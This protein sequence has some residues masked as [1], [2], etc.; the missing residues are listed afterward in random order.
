MLMSIS[1]SHGEGRLVLTKLTIFSPRSVLPVFNQAISC[2]YQVSTKLWPTGILPGSDP[3]ILYHP[4]S[5][6]Y[7]TRLCPTSIS[8]GTGP[9]NIVTR[10]LTTSILPGSNSPAS[11]PA[12]T[13]QYLNRLLYQVQ[14]HL[15]FTRLYQAHTH[16][17]FT[18]FRPTNIL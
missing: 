1:I 5:H 14:T 15:H 13:Y 10:F 12:Q 6:Q 3:S 7:L 17:Y 16:Q 18:R 2:Q 8:P 9:T 11:Y 4:Q